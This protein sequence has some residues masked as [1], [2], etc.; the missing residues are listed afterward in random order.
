MFEH[1][2]EEYD[3]GVEDYRDYRIMNTSDTISGFQAAVNALGSRL[4][5]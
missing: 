2:K 5:W 1:A 4:V 3:G